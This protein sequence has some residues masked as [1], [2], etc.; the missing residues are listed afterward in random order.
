LLPSSVLPRSVLALRLKSCVCV[1]QPVRRWLPRLGASCSPCDAGTAKNS[2]GATC[3][4]EECHPRNAACQQ[5][6]EVG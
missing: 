6:Q 3:P 1:R 4:G 5:A 2:F